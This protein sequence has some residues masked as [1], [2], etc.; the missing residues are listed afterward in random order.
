MLLFCIA[1][2][3]KGRYSVNIRLKC[4]EKVGEFDE[5]DYGWT[6]AILKKHLILMEKLNSSTLSAR[7]AG[8]PALVS[9]SLDTSANLEHRISRCLDSVCTSLGLSWRQDRQVDNCST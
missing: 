4:L 6:V 7:T 9:R 8:Y 5:F 2:V 3:A 1:T